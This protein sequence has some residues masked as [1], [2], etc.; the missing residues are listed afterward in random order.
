MWDECLANIQKDADDKELFD[1]NMLDMAVI[2]CKYYREMTLRSLPLGHCSPQSFDCD[3]KAGKEIYDEVPDEDVAAS[4]ILGRLPQM[5]FDRGHG[6][7]YV[8]VF[9]N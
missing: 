2:M 5:E 9:L 7:V 8:F 1:S 4:W 6:F 3:S